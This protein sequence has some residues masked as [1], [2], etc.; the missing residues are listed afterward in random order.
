MKKI[1]HKGSQKF[2]IL[3]CSDIRS[4]DICMEFRDRSSAINFLRNFMHDHFNRMA[5]RDTLGEQLCQIFRLNDQEVIEQLAWRLVCGHVKIIPPKAPSKL[6]ADEGTSRPEPMDEESTP[7]DMIIKENLSW[8]E[9][10]LV[11]EEATP[12]GREYFKIELPNGSIREGILNPSG[13]FRIDDVEFG[14]CMVAFPDLDPNEW[15]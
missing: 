13:R 5:L 1:F 9:V 4:P 14:T 12:V 7:P 6:P 8:I 15:E 11:D 10:E 3:C 2:A